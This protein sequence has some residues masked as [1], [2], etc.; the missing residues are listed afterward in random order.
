MYQNIDIMLE[1]QKMPLKVEMNELFFGATL[2]FSSTKKAEQ[3]FSPFQ[4]VILIR[5]GSPSLNLVGMATDLH[6]HP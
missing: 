2:V 5:I 4:I 1:E 3:L 6:E